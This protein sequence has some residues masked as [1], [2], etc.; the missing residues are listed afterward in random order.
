VTVLL[1]KRILAVPLG[2]IRDGTVYDKRTI[3]QTSGFSLRWRLEAAR[4]DCPSIAMGSLS[5]PV[6]V[7]AR[8]VSMENTNRIALV[9]YFRCESCG[10][11][12]TL[13]KGQ[14]DGIPQIITVLRDSGAP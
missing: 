6:C 4:Y 11:V 8:V 1:P 9:D 12:W 14:P 10:S 5:C 7:S 13:P 3:F 2:G